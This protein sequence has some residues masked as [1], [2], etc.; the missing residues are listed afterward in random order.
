[1]GYCNKLFSLVSLLTY[2]SLILGFTPKFNKNTGINRI[3]KEKLKDQSI[4]RTTVPHLYNESQSNNY[5]LLKGGCIYSVEKEIINGRFAM[6]GLVAGIGREFVTGESIWTQIHIINIYEQDSILLLLF[7]VV[8]AG[9][10]A[11]LASLKET[12]IWG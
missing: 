2:L 1:M 10:S 8:I 12:A 3:N 11:K 5:K 9:F 4:S 7:G 6:L